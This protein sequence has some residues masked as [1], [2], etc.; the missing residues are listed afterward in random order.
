MRQKMTIAFKTG[1][2]IYE[3]YAII[4][5]KILISVL[6]WVSTE[7]CHQHFQFSFSFAF[8]YISGHQTHHAYEGGKSAC[9]QI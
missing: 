8:Y 3:T 5:C 6:S 4:L 1:M 7:H 9:F 2:Y